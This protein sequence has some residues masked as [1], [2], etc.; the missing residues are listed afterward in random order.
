MRLSSSELTRRAGRL[1]ERLAACDLC[2]RR[3]GVDR[4]RGQRGF[5]GVAEAV[6]FACALP[7]FGEEPPIS[8]TRG[9]G[10]VFFGGCNLGC[11]YCQNHQI[12]RLEIPVAE[13]EPEMIARAMLGIQAAGC[14]NLELVTATHVV[15]QVLAALARAVEAG[16]DLPIVYNSGGYEALDVLAEL[17]GVVDVYLPDLKYGDA[18]AAAELSAAPDYWDVAVAGLREMLRQCGAL[19]VDEH[20][21][22][23]A[24]V[25]V[26][27]LVLPNDLAGSEQVLRFLAALEPRPALSLMAQFYPPEGCTHPLLQRGVG[28]G[29]YARVLR[30]VYDL[31]LET[32]WI[33]QLESHGFCRPD[34]T[35]PVPFDPL[36]PE[37]DHGPDSPGEGSS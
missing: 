6:P 12:S 22:A 36:R 7:H 4:L 17:D 27:H 21:V 5:C 33:Q 14:H 1:R 3:C 24:G 26:R 25:I 28:A 16:L 18:Q 32:G 9:A 29:E 31:E 2:P 10:T 34:F 8:G 37:A 11:L 19:R 35:R 23:R 20:G 30:L 13:V 15:P